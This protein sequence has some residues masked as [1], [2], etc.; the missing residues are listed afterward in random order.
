MHK[1]CNPFRD[2]LHNKICRF[3]KEKIENVKIMSILGKWNK[4]SVDFIN[5]KRKSYRFN[6]IHNSVKELMMI[7]YNTLAKPLTN[8]IISNL[9]IYLGE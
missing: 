3:D 1:Q 5:R 6:T 2:V 7:F 9:F 4:S 8:R